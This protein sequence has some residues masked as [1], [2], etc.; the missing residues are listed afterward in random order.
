MLPPPLL[1][2]IYNLSSS[3]LR[4]WF[5]LLATPSCKVFSLT[6]R[7][8]LTIPKYCG[9]ECCRQF[10]RNKPFSHRHVHHHSRVPIV[11]VILNIPL[12]SYMPILVPVRDA[13][14]THVDFG[15]TFHLS[16]RVIAFG[17]LPLCSSNSFVQCRFW[18]CSLNQP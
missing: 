5:K 12:K 3:S 16:T 14:L 15:P 8:Q 4:T 13:L 18:S 17:K 10:L 2:S 11:H 7:L 1:C 6:Q 9:G